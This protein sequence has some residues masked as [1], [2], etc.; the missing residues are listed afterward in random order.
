MWVGLAFLLVLIGARE[1]VFLGLWDSMGPG[2][3][4]VAMPMGLRCPVHGAMQRLDI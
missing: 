4:A 3:L 2:Q 1:G